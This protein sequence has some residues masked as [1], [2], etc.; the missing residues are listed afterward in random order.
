METGTGL[1]IFTPKSLSFLTV[2]S[3]GIVFQDLILLTIVGDNPA[4]S[5][6]SLSLIS[7]SD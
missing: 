4:A 3:F 1:L 7:S 6:S 5:E 2:E